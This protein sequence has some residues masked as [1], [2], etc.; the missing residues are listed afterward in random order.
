MNKTKKKT[1]KTTESSYLKWVYTVVLTPFLIAFLVILLTALGIF[2]ALPTTI[3]LE[4]PKSNIASEVLSSDQKVLG[5]FYIQNRTNARFDE[6]SPNLVNA[7][8]A[9]E[10][11]RFFKHS[12]VDVIALG[13]VIIKTILGGDAGSGGGSTVS[14]QLAKNLFPREKLNKLQIAFRKIKEWIIAVRLER[15][16]TKEEIIAMYFNTVDFVNQAVGIRSASSIYFNTTP[17]S[18]KLEEAATIVGMLQNP[19]MYNPKRFTEKAELRR[20]VVLSQMEKYGYISKEVRD[21]V[22]QIPLDMSKYKGE[23]HN[24]GLAPYFREHIRDE[25]SKWC[26]KHEKADGTKYNLY[27][28]GLK[29]YTTINSRMQAHA[30]AAVN[31]HMKELQ[32]EFFAHWKGR[33]D[34]PFAFID[35]AKIESILKQSMKR[36]DRYRSLKAAG[37]NEKEIEKDFKTPVEMT[38]F[39]WN[40]DSTLTMSPWD[41]IRYYKHFLRTG[42]MSIEPQTGFVKAW[43]GGINHQYFKYDQVYTGKRQVGSTFKPFVYAIAMREGLSP[44]TE[45]PT[46]SICIETPS[47]PWCPENS[48]KAY[49]NAMVP[50]K[51]ALANSINKVSALLIKTYGVKPVIDLVKKMG[52]TSQLDAVPSISLGSADISLF[53]MVGANA[54]FVNKGIYIQPTYITRIEDKNGNVLEEF[55][56][57]SEEALDEQTA[58]LTIELM[59]GVVEGGTAARLRGRYKLTNPIAGKTGTT[60]NNSDGWFMGLT[61]DLVTGVWVGCEDRSAHFRTTALGQGANTAL[62]IWG[63][64][65]QK[66]YADKKI[67]ISTGDFEKPDKLTV[68]INCE[69]FNQEKKSNNVNFES[70]D[71]FQ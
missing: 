59:K 41:S 32:K 19:S 66:V 4:N 28:D 33:K 64:Y 69:K 62:P 2:G 61:P 65:M 17:D 46:V 57:K 14:Q 42:L 26:A 18:L 23:D 60:Q 63:L 21:S 6:L 3:E 54:T 48:S 9:T 11:A 70:F 52:V 49:E 55:I 7:L 68:E 56:P 22:K 53:E 67:K 29:I 25:L 13:R 35:A 36:S 71:N 43:V 47:G 16:Y 39:T 58:F 27:K 50:L 20:N 37:F 40:G 15:N 51:A 12:G 24:T 30:E 5:K 1:A 45:V 31:E 38:V 8:I 10:D 34:A 44:C